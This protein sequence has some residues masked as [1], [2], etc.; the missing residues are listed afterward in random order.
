MADD[1]LCLFWD[2]C[3]FYAYLAEQATYDLASI[4]LYLSEVRRGKTRIYTS[5]IALAEV[6]PSAIKDKKRGT[7]QDFLSD[8][9]GMIVLVEPNPNIMHMSGIFKDLPYRKGESKKRKLGTPDAIMLA[10]C[11]YQRDA[12]GVPIREFHTFDDGKSKGIEG[13]AIP[14]LSYQEWCDGF[15]ASQRGVAQKIVEL[16]RRRPTHPQPGLPLPAPANSP[17]AS[18]ASPPASPIPANDSKKHTATVEKTTIPA[19]P[20]A[21]PA[22]QPAQPPPAVAAKP[23]SAGS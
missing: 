16:T 7:F 21:A 6:V 23:P 15:S 9:S 19:S 4:E 8:Y 11:L 1:P 18:S 20:P 5:T 14:L 13:R 17:S 22:M 12:I 10:S 2:S 3:V